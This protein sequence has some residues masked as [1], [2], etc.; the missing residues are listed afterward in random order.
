[1]T[2]NHQK[3]CSELFPLYETWKSAVLDAKKAMKDF[4]SAKDEEGIKQ[5]RENFQKAKQKAEQAKKEYENKAYE[6][7]EFQGKE[8]IYKDAL[9]LLSLKEK[10]GKF[11]WKEENGRVNRINAPGKDFSS[12]GKIY[13][14]NNIQRL[15]LMRA[16]IKN[17]ENLN[18]PDNLRILALVHATIQNPENLNLPDNLRGLWLSHATIQNPENLNLPDNLRWIWLDNATIQNPENLNL[19]DN[20]Q[21]IWLKGATM[22]EVFRKKLREYKNRNPNVEIH[23]VEL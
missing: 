8:I 15:V 23:G 10:I 9:S 14:P 1:M 20:L 16:T 3:L 5:A 12:S 6:R 13:F 19:P 2:K 4:A 21:V 7:V 17:P 11:N 22:N 18:L